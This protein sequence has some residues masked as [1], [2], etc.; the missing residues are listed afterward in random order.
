[1]VSDTHMENIRDSVYSPVG[2]AISPLRPD[3]QHQK[4]YENVR[5][6]AGLLRL[7][8]PS[9]AAPALL[10]RLRANEYIFVFVCPGLR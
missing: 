6:S 10:P 2:Q 1:M 5:V 4:R 7:F 8:A 3:T 9:S